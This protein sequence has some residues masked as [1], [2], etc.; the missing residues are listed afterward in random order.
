MLNWAM[1]CHKAQYILFELS[2]TDLLSICLSALCGCEKT[3]NMWL[4][5]FSSNSLSLQDNSCVFEYYLNVQVESFFLCMLPHYNGKRIK[6]FNL[7]RYSSSAE[8]V[9]SN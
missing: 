1:F 7:K 8:K 5:E 9:L 2:V 4:N 6:I 3:I